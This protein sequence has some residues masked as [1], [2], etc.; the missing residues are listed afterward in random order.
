MRRLNNRKLKDLILQLRSEGKSYNEIANKLKCSKSVIS[1][2]CGNGS[3]KKR[4][5][6]QRKL[7]HPLS[8]KISG[9]RCRTSLEEGKRQKLGKKTGVRLKLKTFKRASRKPFTHGAVNNIHTPY[10]YKDV[11]DK[12]G[13][14]PTCYLTGEPINLLNTESYNLDHI[15]PVSQG[16]TNDLSNLQICLKSA[17]QAKGDLSVKDLISL[18]KKIINNKKNRKFINSE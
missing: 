16:G 8:S 4:L 5:K 11:F 9:F 18:C 6:K 12:I 13:E 7:K 10:T 15:I 14:N 3:E 2:H 1:Y 17:N